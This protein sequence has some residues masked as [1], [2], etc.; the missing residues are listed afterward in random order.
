MNIK[1]V[2]RYYVMLETEILPKFDAQATAGESNSDNRPAYCKELSLRI[3]RAAQDAVPEPNFQ[4]GY[5]LIQLAKDALAV[6]TSED[7]DGFRVKIVALINEVKALV[8]S[9]G[10]SE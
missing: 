5:S 6:E 2:W 3:S 8:E 4:M 10:A 9:E 1:K 7:A